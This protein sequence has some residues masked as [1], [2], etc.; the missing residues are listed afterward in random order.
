MVALRG[1]RFLKDEHGRYTLRV[2]AI[3]HYLNPG[4]ACLVSA[5]I[6]HSP[7]LIRVL[8]PDEAQV[9][10][11]HKTDQAGRGISRDRYLFCLSADREDVSDAER[12]AYRN[13]K[14]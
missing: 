3:G 13:E 7:R 9:V 4:H 6:E 10:L 8:V 5:V 2:D 14:A 1:L 12:A 11:P